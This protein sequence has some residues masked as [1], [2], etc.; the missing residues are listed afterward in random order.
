MINKYLTIVREG[1]ELDFD[2]AILLAEQADLESLLAAASELGKAFHGAGFDLCSI[3]NARSGR[4]SEDCR[5]CAQSSHYNT[6][7]LTYDLVDSG[8]AMAQ[9]V[10]NDEYGVKRLSLV[11]AG[12]SLT[13][14]QLDSMGVLYAEMAERTSL[15]FCASMGLL[16]REKAELLVSFGV[17]RYHCNLE[18]CK[19]FFP[20][21][22]TTHTW[23][24]KVETLQIAKA[25]G[26]DL[27]PGGIIGMGETLDQRLQLAFEH[28][29]LEILS[30]PINI[31][32]PIDSTPLE[33]I[34][35][36]S[37]EDVLRCVALFRFINP[38]AVIRIAG[39]RDRF[40]D[41]QYQLFSSGAN[42]AIVGDYLTTGGAG[43]VRD[44]TELAR[45]GFEVPKQNP[46][47]SDDS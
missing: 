44:L 47:S 42:G 23:Q 40:G 16:T 7:I 11:T 21:I 46:D 13:V 19:D 43:A 32:T 1:G 30:I 8:T 5:Y 3:I 6:S 4:C 18:A 38:R 10:A 12:R 28:R 2:Q 20:S 9:A 31:L 36:V 33:G 27:C 45:L 17:R 26:M 37:L 25:A 14:S 41:D 39:G 35:P 24:D 22:C 34:E 15:L 29:D